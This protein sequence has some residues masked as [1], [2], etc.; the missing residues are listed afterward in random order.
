VVGGAQH[1]IDCSAAIQAASSPVEPAEI[2]RAT[3]IKERNESRIAKIPGVVGV[4]VAASADEPGKP[5]ISVYVSPNTSSR[6]V[7]QQVEGV[8]TQI[9]RTGR[10]VAQETAKSGIEE[11]PEE[12]LKR[13]ASVKQERETELLVNPAVVGLGV[14]R[15]EDDSTQPAVVIFLDKHQMPPQLPPQLDGVRTRIIYGERFRATGWN[16]KPIAPACSVKRPPR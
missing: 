13:A 15:S 16:E 9:H 3:A 8:R 7:P 6:S 11:L 10:F 2:A 1:P 4:G 12:S 14:G 5:A